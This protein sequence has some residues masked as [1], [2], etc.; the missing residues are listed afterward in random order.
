MR[1]KA[2]VKALVDWLKIGQNSKAT[3]AAELG[4]LSTDTITKW[5]RNN[6][7]PESKVGRVMAVINGEKNVINASKSN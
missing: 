4:Y 6:A 2:E 3:L 1:Y 5:I 7:I